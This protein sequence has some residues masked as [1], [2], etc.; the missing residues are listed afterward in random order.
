MSARV[1]LMLVVGLLVIFG[2]VML[3]STSGPQGEKIAQNPY[4]FVQRQIAW[5]A[6]GLIAAVVAA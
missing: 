5:L 2:L 4:Y 6:L 3:F 1:I